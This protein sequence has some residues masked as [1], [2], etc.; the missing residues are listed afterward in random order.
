MLIL[1]HF[2]LT[3]CVAILYTDV[4]LVTM[5]YFDNLDDLMITVEKLDNPGYGLTTR[6]GFEGLSVIKVRNLVENILST[7]ST[8]MMMT[9]VKLQDRSNGY[10][11][12]NRVW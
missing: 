10:S 6:V 2:H 4:H 12:E 11:Y 3:D 9:M 5:Q 8:C 7:N 1:N